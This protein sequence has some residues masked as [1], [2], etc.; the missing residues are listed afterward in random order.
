MTAEHNLPSRL[1]VLGSYGML[2][3]A[4]FILFMLVGDVV[5]GRSGLAPIAQP[6]IVS[7]RPLPTPAPTWPAIS[8]PLPVPT[9]ELLSEQIWAGA[10]WMDCAYVAGDPRGSVY[11]GPPGPYF[12]RWSTLPR[13]ARYRVG[14]AC[15]GR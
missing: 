6:T 13:D 8:E 3:L 12:E 1:T 2:A 11:S 9:L 15:D 7:V 10:F 4:T 14:E 5:V